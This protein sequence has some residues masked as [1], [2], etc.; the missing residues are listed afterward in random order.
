V[1]VAT[2][3]EQDAIQQA[4]DSLRRPDFYVVEKV[5]PVNPAEE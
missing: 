4:M 5:E 2:P 1:I 3:S